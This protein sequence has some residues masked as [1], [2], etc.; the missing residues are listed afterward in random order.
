[1]FLVTYAVLRCLVGVKMEM[2]M[3]KGKENVIFQFLI[4]I[5]NERE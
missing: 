4:R 1:M 5:K 2:V 3:E